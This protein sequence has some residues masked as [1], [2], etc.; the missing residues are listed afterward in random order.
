MRLDALIVAF[1][2]WAGTLPR[3]RV[4]GL[5][6]EGKPIKRRPA[7]PGSILA[8]RLALGLTQVAVADRLGI[9]RETLIRLEQRPRYERGVRSDVIRLRQ[10]VT[11]LYLALERERGLR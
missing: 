7:A 3:P 10:R 2:Q 11:D 6:R 5:A 4:L 9:H 1:P 8:R